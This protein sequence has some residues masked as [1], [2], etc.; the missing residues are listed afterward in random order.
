MYWIQRSHFSLDTYSEAIFGGSKYLTI[1][2]IAGKFDEYLPVIFRSEKLGHT[3]HSWVIF[4]LFLEVRE[5]EALNF[6]RLLFNIEVK[7]KYLSF[8]IYDYVSFV[9]V[10]IIK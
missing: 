6:Y 10:L 4:S 3:F 7:S 9:N 2:M 1:E 8:V 5:F